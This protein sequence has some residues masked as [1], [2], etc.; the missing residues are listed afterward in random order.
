MKLFSESAAVSEA[1]L[2]IHHYG[3]LAAEEALAIAVEALS[4]G[5]LIWATQALRVSQAAF[6]AFDGN[7][8]TRF[9]PNRFPQFTLP[10][11]RQAS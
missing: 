1:R 10:H 11:R 4:Q 8:P 6:T 3:S 7:V 9:D 5:D 2:M